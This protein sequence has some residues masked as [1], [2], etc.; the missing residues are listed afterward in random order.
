MCYTKHNRPQRCIVVAKAVPLKLTAE[1]HKQLESIVRTRTLQAQVVY[2]A[3]ILLLKENLDHQHCLPEAGRFR[4]LRR[5][6]DLCKTD[7]AYQ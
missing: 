7:G 5:D 3:R 2:R 1:E 4:L 6:M